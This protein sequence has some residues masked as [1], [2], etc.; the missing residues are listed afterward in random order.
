M[1]S[2]VTIG[3][4]DFEKALGFYDMLLAEMGGKRAFEAPSG[5]FYGFDQ[6]ALLGVLKPFDGEPAA[7]GNGTM[8]ALKVPSEEQV[9][10]V[11]AKALDLG[12]ADEGAPGPRGTRG[13]YAAYFRDF[14]G[15]K[16]CVYHM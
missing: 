1:I 7:S 10:K 11:H 4:N 15:N 12:A 3:T 2:Y 8:V 9:G 16:F 5:Q 14:D 13:F 6:G